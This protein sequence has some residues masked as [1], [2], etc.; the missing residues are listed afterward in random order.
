MPANMTNPA[1]ALRTNT[2]S[3][4]NLDC[5][6]GRITTAGCKISDLGATVEIWAPAGVARAFRNFLMRRQRYSP[7]YFAWGLGS[8]CCT[9]AHFACSCETRDSIL[10]ANKACGSAVPA[11]GPA[12]PR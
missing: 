3:D 6:T 5:E 4:A 12:F 11:Y 2:F 8:C 9:D 7:L 10:S 1:V